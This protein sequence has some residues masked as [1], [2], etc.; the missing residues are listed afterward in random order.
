MH[1]TLEKLFEASSGRVAQDSL[2]SVRKKASWDKVCSLGLPSRKLE[3]WKYT[4]HKKLLNASSYEAPLC[5]EVGYEDILTES[6]LP[7]EVGVLFV[8]GRLIAESIKPLESISG[9]EVLSM[10][11]C[12][13]RSD[14]IDQLPEVGSYSD[15]FAALSDAMLEEGLFIKVDSEVSVKQRIHIIHHFEAAES[16]YWASPKVMV[17]LGKCSQLSLRESFVGDSSFD[18][19]CSS[20]WNVKA[21][22]GS[23]L[24]FVR[25]QNLNSQAS[26]LDHGS[27]RLDRDAKVSI[28][29]VC[30]GGRVSRSSI[31]GYLCDEGSDLSLC[32]LNLVKDQ[33]HMDNQI[34]VIHDSPHTSS[35]QLYKGVLKDKGRLVFNGKVLIKPQAQLTDA[36]QL[37][38]NLVLDDGAEVDTKPNME[39]HADDV[40]CSHGATIG[41]ISPDQLFY[42]TSRGLSELRARE[43]LSLGFATEVLSS[44]PPDLSN[45][46]AECLRHRLGS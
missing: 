43:M 14:V 4:S 7:G 36:K 37:N 32:G 31:D 28:S 27:V 6:V 40:K 21:E 35:S 22:A 13:N 11:S 42:L 5:K 46:L 34:N 10:S 45:Y 39:I 38:A 41:S 15:S 30:L 12:S 23:Q 25:L 17:R 29:N 16:S 24:S 3:A 18:Y 20:S 9:L 8:N 19:M 26:F 1:Q 2:M 33:Q 44:L